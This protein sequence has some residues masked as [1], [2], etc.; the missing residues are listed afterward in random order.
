M[1]HE[2]THPTADPARERRILALVLPELLCELGSADLRLTAHLRQ[3]DGRRAG[4]PPLAVVMI[5]NAEV[6][7]EPTLVIDAVSRAARQF[8][9][10][11]GQT[12]AEACAL[13][14]GLRVRAVSRDRVQ[15]ALARVAEIALTF[16]STVAL[17]A[18][19]T[20]W[21][22]VTGTAHL[23]GGEAELALELASRVRKL[24]HVVRVAVATGPCLA[25]AFA[26][27]GG[28]GSSARVVSGAR[29][30]LELAELPVHALPLQ[31][32][33]VAW[34]ARVGVLTVGQ[35]AALPRSSSAPRLGD[36][37]AAV[38]ELCQG[39]DALPLTAHRPAAVLVEEST[40]DE[41]VSGFQP[42]LFV[43][44]G[45][46]AKMSARLG[47]RGEA[48]QKLELVIVYEPA[49]ARLHQL[50]RELRLHFDLASPL[51]RESELCRVVAARLERTRLEAPSVGLR[52]EAPALIRAMARQLDFSRVL[53]DATTLCPGL[54]QLPVLI[55]ELSA[56]M[57]KARVGVLE[58]V[59]SHRPEKQSHLRP[60]L[61]G[62]DLTRPLQRRRKRRRVD[63]D[64]SAVRLPERSANLPTRL[65][66]EPMPFTASLRKGSVAMVGS[67][68]CSVAQVRFDHRLDAVEWWANS[69]I[70]RDYFRVWL[71]HD[72]GGFET[73]IYVDRASG[74]RYLQAIL[75]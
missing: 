17:D 20:V 71:S 43:L 31:P 48:A 4:V 60:A 72:D 55:A 26:R 10:R 6:T 68:W 66:P 57:G 27:W 19:D 30:A 2:A 52:L 59:D 54:E 67:R 33:I 73:L 25:R 40:W 62:L 9:V 8:G 70:A 64:Q 47:G 16:G 44:R 36:S 49:A 3:A 38:L 51:W 24:G 50:E 32:E 18:P 45:L 7:L 11:E 75:D 63:A 34:L 42:L 53:A 22:D 39:R 1:P 13:V 65:L 29:T 23:F 56:D 74:K 5:A 58:V 41:P 15:A 69:E 14:S 61:P 46:A 28:A 12:I 35:L 37:A 21:V